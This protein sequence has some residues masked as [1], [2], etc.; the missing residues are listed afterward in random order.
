MLKDREGRTCC[1]L[2]QVFR[3]ERVLA[4][5]VLAPWDIRSNTCALMRSSTHIFSSLST[6]WARFSTLL[7]AFFRTDIAR[8]LY[9]SRLMGCYDTDEE[10]ERITH[11]EEEYQICS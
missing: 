8:S 3:K 1:Q 5:V 11:Y 7:F 2:V 4:S 6:E 9:R 10:L